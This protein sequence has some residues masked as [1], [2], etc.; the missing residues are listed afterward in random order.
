MSGITYIVGDATQPLDEGE[1]DCP[2]LLAGEAMCGGRCYHATGN[3]DDT[4]RLC[5]GT[6]ISI[7]TLLRD[8]QLTKLIKAG[9]LNECGDIV[10]AEAVTGMMRDL[11]QQQFKNKVRAV[12]KRERKRK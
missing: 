4:C 9:A 8:Q 12:R 1:A 11:D 2:C 6:G 10:T 7:P 3:T 5:G